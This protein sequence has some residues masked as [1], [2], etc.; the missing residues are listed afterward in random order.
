VT[1]LATWF[2]VFVRAGAMLLAFPLF[3]TVNVPVQ[4]RIALSAGLALIV[5][6]VHA[7]P[8][9]ANLSF[10]S[11]VFLIFVEASVGLLLGFVCRMIF[12]AVEAAG[13]I[14]ATEMGL[15][16]SSQFNPISSNLNAA[17]GMLL[18]WLTVVL[19]FGL[20]MHHAFL[21]GFSTSYTLVPIGGAHLSEALLVDVITRTAKI[22]SVALQM[23]APVIAVSFVVTL[24]FSALGRAVPQI[25]AFAES[26]PVKTLVGLGVFGFTMS[27]MAQ[28]IGNY[29]RRLPE[30]IVHVGRLL[31]G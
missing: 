20:D 18:F 11:L 29:V 3:S 7:A 14:L 27:L 17:P 12:F 21:A 6:P 28:H 2:V 4:V 1:E 10:P 16:M 9:L 31:A 5:A 23:S 25:N 13:S 19:F 30:D 26:A 8:A 15:M 22:F 24:I